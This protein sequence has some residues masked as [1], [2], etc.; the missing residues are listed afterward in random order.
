M[1]KTRQVT[2]SILQ[3]LIEYVESLEKSGLLEKKEML[4]LHDGVQ[5][6]YFLFFVNV[7]FLILCSFGGSFLFS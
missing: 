1:V 3:H 4:E 5:V 2:Y 6:G 7:S